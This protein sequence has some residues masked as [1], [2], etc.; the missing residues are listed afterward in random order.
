MAATK[1]IQIDPKCHAKMR[2]R[3]ACIEFPMRLSGSC[4]SLFT[5]LMLTLVVSTLAIGCRSNTLDTP[6]TVV[7]ETS[8]SNVC[9]SEIKR[10]AEAPATSIPAANASTMAWIVGGTFRMGANDGNDEER[11]VHEVTV[12]SFFMDLHEVSVKDYENCTHAKVCAIP[13]TSHKIDA[14]CNFGKQDQT[15]L[16]MN[17]VDWHQATKFCSWV[18]KRLPTEEEWEYAARG[19]DGRAFVW[20][21]TPPSTQVCWNRESACIVGQF[22]MDKSPFGVMDMG[23]SLREWTSS[24]DSRDYS[25][26]R[27]ADERVA[28]G[29][30]W[31]TKNPMYLRAA[32]RYTHP[33]FRDLPNLGF[34][35][36]RNE[37]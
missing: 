16:P 7:V 33:P 36:A 17:C 2:N 23:G 20:G 4:W 24:E 32:A 30:T 22:P 34:R 18:D 1:G 13:D 28:R 21:N 6:A 3:H 5:G 12:A 14:A 19:R 10:D 9:Q 15:D 35:C 11:P 27:T 29:G 31:D 26:E 8:A 37:R 25:H